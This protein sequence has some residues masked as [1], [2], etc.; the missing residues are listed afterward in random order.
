MSGTRRVITPLHYGPVDGPLVFLAGPIDGAPNWQAE[1]L[2][3]LAEL[4]PEL[5]VANPRREFAP[6]EE[7][8]SEQIDW[9]TGYLRRAGEQGAILFWMAAEIKRVPWRAYAQIARAQLFEAKARHEL[10]GV[11]LVLGIEENFAGGS[12]IRRRFE[13][14][15]VGVPI[16][17]TL[18][19][20]CEAVV[21]VARRA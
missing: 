2:G 7:L 10:A 3:R 15:S 21:H 6:G 19:E 1:A 16:F 13:T 18:A 12:Y 5:A 14:E 4:A 8:A 20:C 11:H 17:R 9:E